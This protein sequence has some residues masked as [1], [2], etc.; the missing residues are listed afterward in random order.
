MLEGEGKGVKSN[1]LD[2]IIS[3]KNKLYGVRSNVERNKLKKLFKGHKDMD[4]NQAKG[5]FIE[6]SSEISTE[7]ENESEPKRTTKSKKQVITF[8]ID[9]LA[10]SFSVD[11]FH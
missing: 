6:K 4:S 11:E 5:S 3:L 10:D 7:N 9:K 1:N 2:D 8:S